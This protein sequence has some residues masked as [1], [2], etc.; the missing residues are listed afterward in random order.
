M[1]HTSQVL[2]INDQTSGAGVLLE[3]TRLR[4]VL[5]GNALGQPQIINM[6][7]D[8]RVKPGGNGCITSGGRPDLSPRAA[9]SGWWIRSCPIPR[10]PPYIDIVVKAAANL[11]HLEEVLVISQD[12]GPDAGEAETGPGRRV[13]RKGPR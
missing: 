1:A 12:V 7:P 2:V 13:R 5:R 10:I 11:G 3:S 9:S 6:L 4:G 8:E